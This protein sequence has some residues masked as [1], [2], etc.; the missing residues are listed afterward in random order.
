MKRSKKIGW[1]IQVISVVAGLSIGIY[2]SGTS[3]NNH[4]EINSGH[5]VMNHGYLDVTNDFP[6][7]RIT[8]LQLNKDPMSGWNLYFEV[9]NFQFAPENASKIH[10]KGEG[11]AHLM[12]NGKKFSRLYSNWYHIPELNF[13]IKELEVTL[14]S[15]SHAMLAIEGIPV[16]KKIDFNGIVNF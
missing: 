6:P 9:E 5:S 12:I 13:K 15:N 10:Q 11:H 8:K 2:F 7:P 4:H 1:T 16:S 14:N 3:I